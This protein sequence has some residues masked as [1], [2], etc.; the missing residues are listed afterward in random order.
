MC[1]RDSLVVDKRKSS[2][3]LISSSGVPP[4]AWQRKR[5]SEREVNEIASRDFF[6]KAWVRHFC[7]R[8]VLGSR[9]GSGLFRA[10]WVSSPKK[11][12][13]SFVPR[14]A[15]LIHSVGV[16]THS[17]AGAHLW[18]VTAQPHRNRATNRPAPGLPAGVRAA[19]S[20]TPRC[21]QASAAG[22]RWCGRSHASGAAKAPGSEGRSG[23]PWARRRAPASAR[24]T[25]AK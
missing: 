8:Q 10:C 21:R 24:A 12:E 6:W 9:P 7:I 1:I 14:G 15:H 3:F 4:S 13:C 2:K 17:A 18:C 23:A 11:K 16:H 25:A 22:G 19:Q 20:A 5:F